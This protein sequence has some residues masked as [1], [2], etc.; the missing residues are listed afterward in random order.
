MYNS[1][2][3]DGLN[4][5]NSPSLDGDKK[6]DVLVVGGGIAGILTAYFLK[7]E[8]VDCILVEAKKI[9]MGITKDT[10]AQISAQYEETYM[11]LKE[12]SAEKAKL[13][14]K[15]NLWAVEKY[16]ELAK[17]I[18]CDFENKA[19]YVYS[20]NDYALIEKEVE[21]AISLGYTPEIVKTLPLPM[22]IAGAY[23]FANQAQFNPLKF[24]SEISKDL[25]VYENTFVKEIKNNIAVTDK[26]SIKA[27]KIVIATHFPF[28]NTSGFYF[29]KMYQNRSYVIAIDNA[30]NLDGMYVEHTA[31][32][33]YFRNYKNYL[34]IGG[35]DHRT[36]K[37]GGNF[38]EIREFAKQY[39]PD[40]HEKYYWATQDCITLDGMPYIGQYSKSLPHV[41]VTTGFNESGM[42]SAIIGARVLTEMITGQQS[43]F[44]EVF[45]PCRSALKKQLFVNLGETFFNFLCPTDKRCPHLG[46]ALKWNK[47]EHTWDCAC[48]GSRFEESGKLI[49]NPAMKDAFLPEKDTNN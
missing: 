15:A 20:V 33:K 40:S 32:G 37:K 1:I 12:E 10:T 22:P 29:V 14:L 31:N 30:P 36:G 49:D 42:T 39:Y 13:F 24:I 9:G 48:H 23:K 16:R 6:C 11:T 44:A 34:L 25:T 26:G 8:G 45:A 47:V 21:T 5:N 17:N 19:S 3:L 41:Y 7:K 28:I 43:E 4:I 2:W 18:D 38:T 46:C 27:N 35:G